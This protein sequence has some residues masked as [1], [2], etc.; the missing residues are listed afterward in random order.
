MVDEVGKNSWKE[1]GVR[2]SA[3][4]KF[5]FKLLRMREVGKS[6]LKLENFGCRRKVVTEV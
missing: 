1:H 3:V 4:G 2:K 5:L 6:I